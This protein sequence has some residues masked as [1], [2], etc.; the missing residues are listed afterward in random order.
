MNLFI[1]FK[2]DNGDKKNEQIKINGI[3]EI[4]TDALKKYVHVVN[5]IIKI[6]NVVSW[7]LILKIAFI[8]PLKIISVIMMDINTSEWF[9]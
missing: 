7:H 1:Y 9:N 2:S 6:F 3:L 4:V 8:A 5:S